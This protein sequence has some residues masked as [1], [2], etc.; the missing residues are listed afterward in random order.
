MKNI[1]LSNDHYLRVYL[2]HSKI[3]PDNFV[4]MVEKNGRKKRI[5]RFRYNVKRRS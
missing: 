1:K 3:V 4:A 5:R 2:I